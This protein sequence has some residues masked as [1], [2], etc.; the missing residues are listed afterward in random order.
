MFYLETATK[1]EVLFGMC[2]AI[3][4][5][6]ILLGRFILQL[7]FIGQLIGLLVITLFQISSDIVMHFEIFLS[8]L[9]LF[10]EYTGD[11]AVNKAN[12]KSNNYVLV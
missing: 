11:L 1:L 3:S 8:S 7:H 6:R 4:S 2:L 12:N 5:I 10:I 9:M